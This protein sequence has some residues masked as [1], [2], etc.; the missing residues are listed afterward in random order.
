MPVEF[1]SDEQAEA[2]GTFAEE[3]TRPEQERF[4]FLDDVDLDLIAL[5][6]TEHHRLGFA[7]QMCT[8][9]Y[10]GLFLEAPL[11]VPWPV[12]EHL[13][14]QLGIEDASVVKR[15]AERRQTPA[16][17]LPAT[18]TSISPASTG[19]TDWSPWKPPSPPC[20][21]CRERKPPTCRASRDGAPT[22]DQRICS[23]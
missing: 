23:P 19:P 18:F 6:R 17:W 21:P 1:L 13:A 4:F 14:V 12:I 10:V 9:R 20:G 7:L 22:P 11:A 16:R 15:Y 2:Y 3:P 5:R 8:V